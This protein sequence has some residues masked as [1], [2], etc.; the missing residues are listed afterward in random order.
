MNRSI[1]TY[2]D[3]GYKMPDMATDP[4]EYKLNEL[5]K[6]PARTVPAILKR[7]NGL[8]NELQ[9]VAEF[10]W[11]NRKVS[12]EA[13]VSGIV[14]DFLDKPASEQ[15]AILSRRMPEFRELLRLAA[16]DNPAPANVPRSVPAPVVRSLTPSRSKRK[17][18]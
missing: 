18:G 9:F 4:A 11:K 17:S 12:A 5:V 7:F 6:I 15:M 2:G 8:L 10:R 16:T 13:V 14:L 1:W 3:W